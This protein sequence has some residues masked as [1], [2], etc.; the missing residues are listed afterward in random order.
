MKQMTKSIYLIAYYNLKPRQHVNTSQV[1]WMKNPQNYSYDE[2][3]EF[4]PKI[5]NRDYTDSGVI[6]DL[7]NRKIVKNQW[8]NGKDFDDLF[9]HYYKGYRE[10]LDPVMTKLGYVST[11]QTKETNEPVMEAS[12]GTISSS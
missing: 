10:Y 7:G 9:F 2:R 5:K 11:E 1:D 6:L 3:V 8:A 4:S 12:S